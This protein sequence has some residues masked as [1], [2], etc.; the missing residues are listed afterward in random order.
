MILASASALLEEISAGEGSTLHLTEV[1][2]RGSKVNGGRGDQIAD[3]L[4]AFGNA[5]GGVLVLGV[6]GSSKEILGIPLSKLD[7]VEKLVTEICHNSIEPSLTVTTQ[8]IKVPDSQ[9]VPRWVL[10]IH[11]ERSLSVHCSPGGYMQRVRSSKRRMSHDQLGRLFQQRSRD[12]LI[13]F[14]D[15]AVPGTVL[16]DIEP[17]LLSRFRTSRTIGNDRMLALKLG[18]AVGDDFG[19]TRLTVAGVLLGTSGPERWLRHAYIQAVAYLGNSIGSA[20]SSANYQIDAQDIVG[21]IDAQVS[22]AC[23]FVARNQRIGAT[24]SLGRTDFPQYDMTAVFE[25]LVNAVAHRDYSMHGSRIRLRMFSDR[26]ELYSPGE[27]VNTLTP[28]TLAYRQATRNETITSLLARCNMPERVP[29]LSS[30]RSTM[31]DRRGEG[32]PL[33]LDLS[34]KISGREPV[35]ETIDPSELRLTIF[36]VHADSL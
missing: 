15:I 8:K 25:A 21:P 12:R 7:A 17:N 11:V 20:M 33:I 29:G 24:K 5:R 30:S 2:F 35:F 26:L 10:R 13:R 28:D 9:G 23:R 1:E 32:V 4:A 6:N 31:M 3:E 27:L 14:D 34:E 22:R 18:M 16:S 36:G 19:A